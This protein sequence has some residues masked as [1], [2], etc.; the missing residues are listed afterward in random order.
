MSRRTASKRVYSPRS[1]L[2]LAEPSMA[3]RAKQAVNDLRD[4]GKLIFAS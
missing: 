4:A 1:E 3:E 2:V